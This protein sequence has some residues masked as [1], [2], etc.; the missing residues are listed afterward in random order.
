MSKKI[1]MV[2]Q[3]NQPFARKQMPVSYCIFCGKPMIMSS[4]DENGYQN[5]NL[6]WEME[7]QAHYEC[8]LKEM[9]KREWN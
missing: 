9:S 1:K 7:H 8:Y 2:K 5:R 3:S 6:Q 4:T